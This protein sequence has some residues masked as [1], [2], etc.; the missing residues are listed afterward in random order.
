MT[1]E[2]QAGVV[3][4]LLLDTKDVRDDGLE[5]RDGATSGRGGGPRRSP[6][7]GQVDPPIFTGP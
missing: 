1:F 4:E 6:E 7:I 3:S 2:G 5:N